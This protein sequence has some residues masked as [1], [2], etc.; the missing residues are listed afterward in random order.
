MSGCRGAYVGKEGKDILVLNEF[1]CVL[2]AGAGI[3]SIVAGL[4]TDFPSFYTALGVEVVNVGHD[5]SVKFD[6][7]GPV[8]PGK[9]RR[10]TKDQLFGLLGIGL[11]GRSRTKK[12]RY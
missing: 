2:E 7:H 12:E 5:S 3:I 9:G 8:G 1:D 4:D 11:S 6:P 10:H